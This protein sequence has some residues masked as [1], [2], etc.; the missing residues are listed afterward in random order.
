[1]PIKNN[2]NGK[3]SKKIFDQLVQFGGYG[4]NKAHAV[5]YA[6][7]AYQSAYLK[8]NYPKEHKKAI[9][10]DKN[11]HKANQSK[12]SIMENKDFYDLLDKTIN[13][14]LGFDELR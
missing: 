11:I 9:K 13:N 8:A 4:F 3:I 2:I 5:S 12:Y 14:I 1:M 6:L 10:A 7:L